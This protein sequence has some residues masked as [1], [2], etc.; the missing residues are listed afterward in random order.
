MDQPTTRRISVVDPVSRA[1][2]RV[3]KVLFDPFDLGKW[4]ILGFGAWLATL[5]QGGWSGPNFNF[6]GGPSGGGGRS[7][8]DGFMQEIHRYLPLIIVIGVAAVLLGL[9]I[10]A[11]LVW[12]NSRGDFIFADCVARNKAQVTAPW[13]HYRRAGNSLF[14][15]RV[16]VVI[17]QSLV[18]LVLVGVA[19]LLFVSWSRRGQEPSPAAILVPMGL[20]FLLAFPIFLILGLF[21]MFLHDFAVPIMMLRGCTCTEAWCELKGLLWANVGRTVLYVLFRWLLNMLIGM[22]ILALVICTCCIAACFLGIPYIGTVLL[23]PI[24]VFQR[25][26]SLYYLA[27][28]GPEYDVFGPD[29]GEGGEETP[30]GA[31]PP[32]GP[33]EPETIVVG[34]REVVIG[35]GRQEPPRPPE[36]NPWDRISPPEPPPYSG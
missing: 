30:Q 10:K 11:V 25:S 6:G 29:G 9:A 16:G 27:Q 14:L 22:I 33:V 31:V 36:E 2:D 20:A 17:V 5:G 34:P 3:N 32:Q 8:F 35:P 24:L 18:I 19:L 12:L 15:V 28:Y 13:R 26:Y 1:L 21:L 23:L 4:F 7:G